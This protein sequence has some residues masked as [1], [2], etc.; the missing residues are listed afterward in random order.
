M[1][2]WLHSVHVAKRELLFFRLSSL[3]HPLLF[4]ALCRYNSRVD[5]IVQSLFARIQEI[6]SNQSFP[7]DPRVLRPYVDQTTQVSTVDSDRRVHRF[8]FAATNLRTLVG[9]VVRISFCSEN[10]IT[11]DFLFQSGL[12]RDATCQKQQETQ[13]VLHQLVDHQF[14][15]GLRDCPV[16][17]FRQT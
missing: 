7:L 11:Y 13:V 15:Y 6:S 17:R 4:F 10:W 3:G 9:A 1:S 8:P 16:R 5:L 2:L 12:R 14:P